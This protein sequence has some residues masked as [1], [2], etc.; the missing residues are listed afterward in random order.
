MTGKT[1]LRT[2]ADGIS[3]PEGPRWRHGALWFSDIHGHAVMHLTADGK[4]SKVVG[5]DDRPSGLGF[6]ADGTL[7]ISAMLDRKLLAF[8]DGKLWTHADLSP[9]CAS[10]INDMVVD[11]EGR[12]YVGGR[13]GGATGSAT[14]NVI[15][16]MPDGTCRVVAEDMV[17]PNGSAV[18]PDGE[19]LIVAEARI[20]RLTRFRIKSDGSLTNRETMAERPGFV[21][22]G[23]CLDAEGAVWCGGGNVGAYRL[24]ADGRLLDEIPN[25]GRDTLAPA[26]GGPNGTTLYLATTGFELIDNLRYIGSDRRKD[27][28]VNSSGQ[29]DIVEVSVPGVEAP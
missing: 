9:H 6:L 29:I 12:A 17:A 13:N 26:L 20:G 21:I 22:D 25:P 7:L 10:F 14:D 2:L 8:K 1:G 5:I 27:A 3:F 11:K 4:L 24:G 16:A 18:T 23:I 15:L 28:E 19:H